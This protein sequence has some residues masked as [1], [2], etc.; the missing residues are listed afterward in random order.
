MVPSAPQERIAVMSFKNLRPDPRHDWMQQALVEQFAAAL[1]QVVPFE[2]YDERMV[3]FL[4][5]GATDSLEAAQRAD[6]T[7]LVDGAYWVSD[8]Q[9][10]IIAHVQNTN[11]LKSVAYVVV[12]GPLEKFSELTNQIVVNLLEQ[13]HVDLPAAA[14]KQLR[15]RLTTDLSARKLLFDAEQ[16][17]AEGGT[18]A[19]SPPP[20][21]GPPVPPGAWLLEHL[22]MTAASYAADDYDPEAELRATLEGYRSAF[23]REDIDGLARYYAEFTREQR[24]AL[25]SYFLNAAQLRVRFHDIHIAV[26]GDRAA[27]SFSR[28]DHFVDRESGD[29]QQVVVRVTKVFAKGAAGWQIVPE[30]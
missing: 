1:H 25:R 12:E 8:G 22:Y 30:P 11:P 2:I 21:T 5:R 13:M 18:P 6:M 27:V 9:L 23:E 20:Q 4:A 7:K 29:A 17:G 10:T 24:T 19:P 16:S 26:I 3:R 28:E 14:I 15:Q